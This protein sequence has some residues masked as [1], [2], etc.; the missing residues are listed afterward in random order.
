MHAA[1]S[2]SPASF[3]FL[4]YCSA[5]SCD[6]AAVWVSPCCLLLSA[7][8]PAG[9]PTRRGERLPGL[10]T[11]DCCVPFWPAHVWSSPPTLRLV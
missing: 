2:V 6:D 10:R 1:S 3:L 11:L 8:E 5:A 7:L 9:V 4:T